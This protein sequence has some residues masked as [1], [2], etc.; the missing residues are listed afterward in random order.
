MSWS[1]RSRI[2]SRPAH[3]DQNQINMNLHIV[4]PAL[5]EEGSIGDIVQRCLDARSAIARAPIVDQVDVTVVSDGSTDATATL[6]RSFEPEIR[7]VEFAE[8]RGYGAAIQAGWS[9]TD[10]ELLAFL[11]ADGTCEPAFFEDLC[12]E[13]ERTDADIVLGSRLHDN[14]EM[15]PVRRLGNR[16]F[17]TLLSFFSSSKVRDTASGMR[18]VRRSTLSRVLPLPDG[19][20]FTPAM[21]AKA[22]LRS[23]VRISEIEMPYSERAGESK[24]NVFSDGFR[25]LGVIL[26]AILV[27][28][29][30][31]LMLILALLSGLIAVAL[32]LSPVLSYA[33]DQTVEEWMIYRFIVCHFL[34]TS[35]LIGLGTAFLNNQVRDLSGVSRGK[36][37][38]MTTAERFILSGWFWFVPAA[39]V[40]VGISLVAPAA[41]ELTESSHIYEH[42]SR[43][44]VASFFG[45]TAVVLIVTRVIYHST[46]H[47]WRY[48]ALNSEGS[49]PPSVTSQ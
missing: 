48:M 32:M 14:S 3:A 5:N 17:S 4:I 1:Q 42:W 46:E 7:V 36:S 18:V 34:A 44:V 26:D 11:D 23:D 30:A 33:H 45:L 22:L 25:F 43:F 41:V 28:R 49:T 20:D 39:C 47:L 6:A 2:D 40:M 29:P 27:Y 15:P 19:L 16:V 24:L 9:Q 13:M 35:A 37:G 12:L 8:N 10:A 21:S 31:R 38:L